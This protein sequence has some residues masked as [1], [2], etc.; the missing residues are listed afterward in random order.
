MEATYD[1]D[2]STMFA[3]FKMA[4]I[5]KKIHGLYYLQYSF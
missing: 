1:F 3:I 2:A 5:Q 4:A